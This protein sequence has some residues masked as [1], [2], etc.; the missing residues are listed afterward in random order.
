MGEDP[1]CRQDKYCVALRGVSPDVEIDSNEFAVPPNVR[2][3]S[4]GISVTVGPFPKMRETVALRFTIT[5]KP[6]TLENR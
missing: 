2:V 6:V 4:V 5:E 1:A 3:S